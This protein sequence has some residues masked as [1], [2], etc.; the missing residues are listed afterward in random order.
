MFVGR[1]E[2]LQIMQRFLNDPRATALIVYGR[3]RIGKTRMIQEAIQHWADNGLQ[4]IYYECKDASSNLNYSSFVKTVKK[5][6]HLSGRTAFED[7]E[8]L[9]DYLFEIAAE[10]P[11]VLVL[12]EYSYLKANMDGIDSILQNAIDKWK[13]RSRLKLILSGS[14]IDMMQSLLENQNPLHGRFEYQIKL[15]AMDYYD[16]A[17][18]YPKMS[19]L[20]RIKLYSVFGGVPF[21]N[22]LIDDTETVEENIL[23]LIASP[24]AQ[25]GSE[26]PL[27]LNSEIRKIANANEVFNALALGET[28]F[29]RIAAKTNLENKTLSLILGKL[30]G[31]DL[32]EKDTPI[33]D[34][35]NAKKT[36][37]RIKDRFSLFY[38]KYIFPYSQMAVMSPRVFY[39]SFIEPDFST[40]FV[41]KCFEQ[42]C[43]EYLI[44]ANKAGLIQP[45]FFDIGRYY[46]DLPLERKNGEFDN[47][48]KS[49]NGY[50]F[51][52]SKFL[53][54]P[55][56]SQTVRKEIEQVQ[57][58]GLDCHQYG[59]ISRSGFDD[60]LAGE[61]NIQL[62]SLEELFRDE[63]EVV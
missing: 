26:I 21:Y 40:Q 16:S 5:E 13:G 33:N 44:R 32:I 4:V 22:S 15:E 54:S 23:R 29:R 7:M 17:K 36:M 2:E 14:L 10:Q 28:R 63:L 34:R 38:Y 37:Y 27:L 53:S 31:M 58:C 39:S 6:L 19:L 24:N 43:R 51:Y 48:V 59:F 55:V 47:V 56:T 3:R 41:P 62:I 18:F 11:V 9:L 60:N 61:E 20:D 45:P 46:Y 52:E 1:K 30:C 57:T 12:D 8:D 42:V 25:L 50:T 35:G 49:R